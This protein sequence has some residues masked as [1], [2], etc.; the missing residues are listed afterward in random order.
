MAYCTASD[1]RLIVSTSLTDAEISSMIMMSDAEIDKK[2]GSQDASNEFV[3]KLSMLLTAHSI[4]TR[5]S[6]SVAIGEY[7]E[8]TGDV[9]SGFDELRASV[10]VGI[11]W[12]FPGLGNVPLMIDLAVP[13]I[14]ED[15]D[16]AQAFHFSLGTMHTF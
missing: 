11:R 10:G 13:F 9:L 14:R 4:K 6:K 8:D 3:K 15:E 2:I 16:D 5:Q 12:L 1:V 7:R